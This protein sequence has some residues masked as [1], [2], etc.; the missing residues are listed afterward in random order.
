[1]EIGTL[2]REISARR[3][4]RSSSYFEERVLISALLARP[5]ARFLR[6]FHIIAVIGRRRSLNGLSPGREAAEVEGYIRHLLGFAPPA[7]A[8]VLKKAM[9]L[10]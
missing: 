9:D 6:E 5:S 10:G 1:V 3:R 2:T 7:A 8:A 4:G